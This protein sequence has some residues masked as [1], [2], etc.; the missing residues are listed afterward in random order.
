MY[1]PDQANIDPRNP[2]NY[3]VSEVSF[4][5]ADYKAGSAGNVTI[6][7]VLNKPFSSQEDAVAAIQQLITFHGDE[8]DVVECAEDDQ[9]VVECFEW[10]ADTS[11]YLKA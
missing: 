9:M 5:V 10:D 3:P 2:N 11:R 8:L 6:I 4:I 1:C 7:D